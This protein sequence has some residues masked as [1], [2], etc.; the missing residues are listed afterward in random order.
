[1]YMPLI[2]NTVILELS[3]FPSISG[4]VFDSKDLSANTRG[5]FTR[6]INHVG[7]GCPH[8]ACD[9]DSSAGRL[10]HFYITVTF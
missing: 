10:T 3:H 9:G 7:Q 4:L 6:Y 2:N 1:M 8:S 5:S